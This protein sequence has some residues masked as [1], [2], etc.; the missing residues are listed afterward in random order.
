MRVANVVSCLVPLSVGMLGLAACSE[1]S[2]PVKLLPTSP[3][4]EHKEGVA[5]RFETDGTGSCSFNASPEA[6]N[7]AALNPAEFAEAA[8]CGACAEVE[9]STG[10]VRVRVVSNCQ[11]CA[12]NQ[13]ALSK[14]AFATMGG[15]DFFQMQVRWRYTTC[16]LEGP[17]R[18][19][20]KEDSSAYWVALQVRNHLLPIQQLAWQK[21]GA[22]VAVKREPYNYFIEPQ[23]MGAGPVRLRVTASNGQQLED[24]LPAIAPGALVDGAAQFSAE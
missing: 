20:I 24:T 16:P 13:L 1:S 22:W 18:Y 2:P 4:S 9:S 12:P 6:L 19:F 10:S 17:V 5:V 11:G 8:R 3:L 7:V 23:G 15:G 21:D 14:E